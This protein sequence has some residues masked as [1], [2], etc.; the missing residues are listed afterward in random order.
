VKTG[1]KVMRR[2]RVCDVVGAIGTSAARYSI[3]TRPEDEP[4]GEMS[5]WVGD[6]DEVWQVVVQGE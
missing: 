6:P 3:T 1:M 5:F 4:N 2:R